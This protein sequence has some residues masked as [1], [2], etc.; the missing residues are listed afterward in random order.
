MKLDQSKYPALC[1]FDVLESEAIARLK[2][3]RL[4]AKETLP[5]G[6]VGEHRNLYLILEGVCVNDILYQSTE[7]LFVSYKLLPGEFVG[8]YEILS[9]TIPEQ[10]PSASAKTPATVLEIP[11]GEMLR[12]QAEYPKLYNHVICEVLASH[13]ERRHLNVNCAIKNS[14]MSGAYYL[15]YLYRAYAKGCH[16]TGYVGPVKIWDTRHE[17]GVALSCSTRSVDRIIR[18]FLELGF[19]RVVNGKITITSIQAA[20]L[21][22][23]RTIRQ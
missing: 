1:I 7:S 22:E 12:W 18:T 2:L 10:M 11:G 21:D 14:L 19:L 13:F 5:Q 6:G 16:P 23:Y 4:K 8:L 9:G 15:S 3:L 17:I 20:A